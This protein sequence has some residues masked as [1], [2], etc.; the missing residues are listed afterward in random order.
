M[1]ARD[2][3]CGPASPSGALRG[4]WR[5]LT[6]QSSAASGAGARHAPASLGFRA[7]SRQSLL[8]A[9]S[10]ETT[11]GALDAGRGLGLKKVLARLVMDIERGA[12]CELIPRWREF[13]GVQVEQARI[14]SA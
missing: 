14:K 13:E 12:G 6:G 10:Q 11:L 1:W 5:P 8:T 9:D 2:L 7:P 4:A 3:D